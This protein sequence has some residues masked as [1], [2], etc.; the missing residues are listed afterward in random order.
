MSER[1]DPAES[2]RRTDRLGDLL[3]DQT[4]D[5]SPAE[6]GDRED[7]DADDEHLRREV[8]PHHG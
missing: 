5:E 6:W 1:D 2:R 3:P 8:P 7:P 4:R